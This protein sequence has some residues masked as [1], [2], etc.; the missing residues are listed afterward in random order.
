MVFYENSGL[1]NLYDIARY[2]QVL[3]SYCHKDFACFLFLNSIKLTFI[4]LTLFNWMHAL[5]W[6]GFVHIYLHVFILSFSNKSFTCIKKKTHLTF[7]NPRPNDSKYAEVL[8]FIWRSIW[9]KSYNQLLVG[10]FLWFLLLMILFSFTG[11]VDVHPK[12]HPQ[13]HFCGKCHLS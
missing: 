9:L 10:T 7:F 13:S 3:F 11:R 12:L 4:L 2:C 6:K 5:F 1:Q 8:L